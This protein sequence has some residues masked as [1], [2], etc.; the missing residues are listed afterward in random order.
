[1][2][3]QRSQ[4]IDAPVPL[5][6]LYRFPCSL[7]AP[8]PLIWSFT[9]GMEH[10]DYFG[11]VRLGMLSGRTVLI[12]SDI[13]R[14][15]SQ[16]SSSVLF[17]TAGE[18]E[19]RVQNALVNRYGLRARSVEVVAENETVTIRATVRSFYA[20]QLLIHGCLRVPGVRTVIDEICVEG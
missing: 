15:T 20:R 1:M 16:M 9:V 18:L 6:G 14:F 2:L 12:S 19:R 17:Q 7:V 3:H 5:G 13:K 10:A 4:E 8:R 11:R